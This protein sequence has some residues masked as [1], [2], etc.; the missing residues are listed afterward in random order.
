LSDLLKKNKNTEKPEQEEEAKE[1]CNIWGWGHGGYYRLSQGDL[2]HH[3]RPVCVK[4][5]EKM[6]FVDIVTGAAHIVALTEDG[7]VWSWG[8]CHVGQLGHGKDDEDGKYPKQ[9]EAL[10][11]IPIKKIACGTSHVLLISGNNEVY[12]NGVG[13]FGTTGH[14]DEV[15]YSIPKK[16]NFENQI[17]ISCDGGEFHSTFLL[18]D[19]SVFCC[20]KNEFG[21]IGQD[22]KIKVSKIPVRVTGLPEINRIYCGM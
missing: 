10:K 22:T 15:S 14:G 13:Y 8:K 7:T 11:N 2:T 3:A 12:T 18:E 4:V 16:L 19:G 6:K 17:V 9:I 21:Q 1:L 5:R 20:G